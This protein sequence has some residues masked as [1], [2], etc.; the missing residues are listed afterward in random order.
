VVTSGSRKGEEFPIW[1]GMTIGRDE[2]RDIALTDDGSVSSTHA[3]FNVEGDAVTIVDERSRNG[4][5]VNGERVLSQRLT[6]GDSISIGKTSFRFVDPRQ[7]KAE[8]SAA[9]EKKVIVEVDRGRNWLWIPAIAAVIAVV[10]IGWLVIG[11]LSKPEVKIPEAL[12]AGDRMLRDGEYDDAKKFYEQVLQ[13]APM[14]HQANTGVRRANDYKRAAGIYA[15]LSRDWNKDMGAAL[16]RIEAALRLNPNIEGATTLKAEL[17]S[18]QDDIDR[19]STW[20]AQG[21]I[22]AAEALIAELA[23]KYPEERQVV[24]LAGMM[25][26][27][28]AAEKEAEEAEARKA[29]AVAPPAPTPKPVTRE[30]G[31]ELINQAWDAFHAFNFDRAQGRAKLAIELGQ[32]TDE[33]RTISSLVDLAEQA[34]AQHE[35]GECEEAID[36]WDR[37]LAIDP[38]CQRARMKREEAV[39]ALTTGKCGRPQEAFEGAVVPP[40]VAERYDD[41]EAMAKYR[42]A[43]RMLDYAGYDEAEYKRLLEE[44]LTYAEPAGQI[45][46]M[47]VLKLEQVD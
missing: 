2:G 8:L 22:A 44:A 26:D 5:F 21:R 45:Y 41:E 7:E 4:V 38:R 39:N 25:A 13:I 12:A 10:V 32:M 18:A 27:R 24:Q 16:E 11:N 36:S 47:I 23:E 17:S 9:A 3:F 46:K 30:P 28:E 33:A 6:H 37:L 14:N 42:E 19:A 1:G 43:L 20:V 29:K 15:E 34:L 31:E 40:P 35:R